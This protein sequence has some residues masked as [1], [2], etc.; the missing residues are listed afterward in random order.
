MRR[1][2]QLCRPPRHLCWQQV[3]QCTHGTHTMYPRY[4][5]IYPCEAIYE[6]TKIQMGS[7]RK[8]R[9]AMIFDKLRNLHKKLRTTSL[10]DLHK[11]QGKTNTCIAASKESSHFFSDGAYT[12]FTV[13]RFIHR[14]RL[15]LLKLNVYN[16]PTRLNP[17]PVNKKCWKCTHVETL[18]HVLDHCMVHSTHIRKDTMLE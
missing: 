18:H 5:A 8:S 11:H 7:F 12:N 16:K 14:A 2:S 6:E 13:W 10:R 4:I 1:F 9:F 3:S 17:G 15:L